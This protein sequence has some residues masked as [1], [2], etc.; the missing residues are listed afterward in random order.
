MELAD[1]LVTQESL[2]ILQVLDTQDYKVSPVIQEWKVL[3][4]HQ[5]IAVYQ[6]TQE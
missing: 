2:E 6:D 3:L 4:Q 1:F 5:V